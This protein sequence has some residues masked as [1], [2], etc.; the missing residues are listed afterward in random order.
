MY[1]DAW[2]EVMQFL[3]PI[4]VL[5]SLLTLN[6][7]LYEWIRKSSCLTFDDICNYCAGDENSSRGLKISFH[8]QIDDH[9]N[10]MIDN[11]IDDYYVKLVG[12]T[13]YIIRL[14]LA[15]LA[16]RLGNQN[17]V[18]RSEK[19]ISKILNS[20]ELKLL[21]FYRSVFFPQFKYQESGTI[22]YFV[23]GDTGIGKTTFRYFICYG[24]KKDSYYGATGIDFLIKRFQIADEMKCEHKIF[25]TA[26]QERF[27]APNMM[28]KRHARNDR[29][30]FLLCFSM[31][32]L[33]SFEKL[34]EWFSAVK[35]HAHPEISNYGLI[36]GLH[37]Q[38]IR[39]VETPS[40]P[41]IC[42]KDTVKKSYALGKSVFFEANCNESKQVFAPFWFIQLQ[43]TY[44]NNCKE[45]D[46]DLTQVNNSWNCSIY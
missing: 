18:E 8:H 6:R 32:H 36:V 46:K 17:P 38:N 43:C 37:P 16:K 28:V 29:M 25:D 42:V 3:E 27:F 22:N 30:G 14:Y 41:Q 23:L 31:V 1:Q 20:Y 4:D 7:N 15:K 24:K 11:V 35:E 33:V 2:V 39:W 10:S 12:N 45:K 26:G 13:K 44:F 40:E 19:E 5:A 34:D 9:D 21:N